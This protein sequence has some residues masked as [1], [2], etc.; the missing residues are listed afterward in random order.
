MLQVIGVAAV[1]IDEHA[2]RA[3]CEDVL[4]PHKVPRRIHFTAALP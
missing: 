2:V 3:R 4:L 1:P